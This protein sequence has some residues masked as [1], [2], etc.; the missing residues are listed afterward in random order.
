[1]L[2]VEDI[3]QAVSRQLECIV[4]LRRDLHRQPE[5]GGQ[6]AATAAR[7]AEVLT[8]AGLA[9]R[10]DVA[11]HGLVAQ[12]GSGSPCIGLR[13]DMDAL[14]VAEGTGLAWASEC[15]GL[16]HA[17]GHDFHTAWL[18]GAAL[19]LKEVGLP[20]GSVKFI[21]QPAEEILSGARGMIAA[22]VLSDEPRLDA[23][24]AGHVMPD[25]LCGR[26]ALRPGPN[27]AAADSFSI[28]VKGAGTHGASPHRG[29]DPIPVA[30]EIVLAL[31][32]LVSRR[33]DPLDSAVI[34]V[35]QIHAGSA[36]NIIPP[37]VEL[38]GTVRTLL[39]E[40]QELLER[41]IGHLARNIAAAH[42]CGIDYDFTR[43][44]PATVTDPEM[45]R[46]ATEAMSEVLSAEAVEVQ[47][48][49]SMG[50]EDFSYF[51]QQVPGAL[52]WVGCAPDVAATQTMSLHHPH[53]CPDEGC[54]ETTMT[55]FA[56]IALAY[57]QQ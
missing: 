12:L 38:N 36:F 41:E 15:P 1:M 42:H 51:L 56:A 5:L 18:V 28:T 25:R 40:H 54:L 37:E 39:P 24:V 19:V 16:M 48:R 55:A 22:G 11:G 4:A 43:G 30:A 9:V 10:T 2:P 35:G 13:S 3:T 52:L 53:F 47:E 45:T 8:G 34:T 50:G 27:L 23:V 44:V 26:I 31:Q 21:F 33:M 57:L 6:E 49:P 17:C 14:P 32:T 20:R 7:V 46:L 29:K